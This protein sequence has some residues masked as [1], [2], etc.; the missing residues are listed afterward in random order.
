MLTPPHVL[1]GAVSALSG[2]LLITDGKSS[3]AALQ[4]VSNELGDCVKD[5]DKRP[6]WV[7][8]ELASVLMDGLRVEIVSFADATPHVQGNHLTQH[9]GVYIGLGLQ[10]SVLRQWY[11]CVLTI[12]PNPLTST[13][14][15]P[16][17]GSMLVLRSVILSTYPEA[18]N[19]PK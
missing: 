14:L 4:Q 10:V 3:V 12:I 18:P 17:S 15:C 16:L 7:A 9:G 1:D 19:S 6:E 8:A 13:D 11:C 5:A 2:R